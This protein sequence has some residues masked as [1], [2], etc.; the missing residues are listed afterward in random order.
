MTT[1][2]LHAKEMPMYAT[3]NATSAA[4]LWAS[5]LMGGV[6][7]L[8]LLVDGAMKLFKPAVVVESSAQL[9]YP[10]STLV[11]IGLALLV[12]TV[13]YL[14]PRTSVLGA[15]LL[16]GYLGG[17]VATHVRVVGP[18]FNIVFPVLLGGLL[19][20]SLWLR[21]RRLQDLLPLRAR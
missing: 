2:T 13:L 3:D 20:G 18:A 14:V 11:G 6:P 4:R 1:T 16:T 12:S 17:A 5:R 9:G 10:E 7:A 21:D 8:F 19:W 15:V